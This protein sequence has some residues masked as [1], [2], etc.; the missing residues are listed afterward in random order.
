MPG[1][2]GLVRMFGQV[3]N[4]QLEKTYWNRQRR[5]DN[6]DAVILCQFLQTEMRRDGARGRLKAITTETPST[7]MTKR[8]SRLAQWNPHICMIRE[9]IRLSL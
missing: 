3:R 5:T 9:G 6:T 4:C 7:R 1:P 2:I 8:P